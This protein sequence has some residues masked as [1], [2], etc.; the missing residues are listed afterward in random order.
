MGNDGMGPRARGASPDPEGANEFFDVP[1]TVVDP[2]AGR[3]A[4][5]L[6]A[7]ARNFGQNEVPTRE[8]KNVAAALA[9]HERNLAEERRVSDAST[10]AAGFD[11]RVDALEEITEARAVPVP[12]AEPPRTFEHTEV[13]DRFDINV[14]TTSRPS[15]LAERPAR[16][17]LP[18][19]VGLVLVAAVAGMGVYR[20]GGARLGIARRASAVTAP[21]AR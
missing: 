12:P 16:S 9:A 13:S 7:A 8:S 11:L 1:A 14:D 20:F 15:P 6:I 17:R 3:R 4:A 2:N 10:P 5:A 18:L 19:V 21:S